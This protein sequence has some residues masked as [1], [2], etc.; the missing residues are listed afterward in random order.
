MSEETDG[1]SRRAFLRSGAGLAAGGAA[2][3]ALPQ[4]ALAQPAATGCAAC[5]R[6]GPTPHPAQGRG[7][8][9]PRPAGG[10]FRAGRRPDRGRQDPRGQARHR[11]IRRDG[12]G[13]RRRQ[14]HRAARLHRHPPPF[15]SR[16]PAQHPHQRP[17]QSRL[18]PRRQQH[19]DGG[20]S[21][22][23]RLCRR[24]G[25]GARHDRW[26]HHRGGRHLAGLAH[27]RAQR[28]RHRGAAGIRPARRLCLFARRRARRQIPAGHRPAAGDRVQLERPAA[29]AGARR[30]ASMRRYSVSPARPA[31]RRSRTASAAIPSGCWWSSAAWACWRPATNTSTATI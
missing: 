13:R 20:L 5:P 3:Q 15:L 22:E 18:Q 14:P 21:A 26:R 9:E 29:D 10:R 27:P 1:T 25:D 4:G 30:H 16:H 11:G 8:A 6:A 17:A 2:A 31:C 24:A 28:R 12:R 7:G 23:R 19:P